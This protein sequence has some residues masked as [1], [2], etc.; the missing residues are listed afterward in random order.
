MNDILNRDGDG[1]ACR[2]VMLAQTLQLRQSKIPHLNGEGG[3]GGVL[4]G[5]GGGHA[6][7]ARRAAVDR[8]ARIRHAL[9]L[10]KERLH[11]V[12][13]IGKRPAQQ[14]AYH[15]GFKIHSM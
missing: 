4:A 14:R 8:R 2:A 3:A 12:R 11:M 10:R 6:I 1:V 13:R 9:V 5:D 15:S 7:V